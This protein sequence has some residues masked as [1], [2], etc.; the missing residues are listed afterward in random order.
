MVDRL[1]GKVRHHSTQTTQYHNSTI[2]NAVG[3]T[4]Q[5]PINLTASENS[6]H[7]HSS[8]F[9]PMHIIILPGQ[10]KLNI[11]AVDRSLSLAD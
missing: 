11:S 1:H 10:D 7:Q 3:K 8:L 4:K 5:H 6:A 9:T 2:N